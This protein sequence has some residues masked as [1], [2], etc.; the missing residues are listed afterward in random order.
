[1][2]FNLS[3]NQLEGE[4]PREG[5]FKNISGVSIIGNKE[6]CGGIPE[7][8]L[9]NCSN[10][11]AK[12]KGNVLSTKVIV[13]LIVSI[14]LASM[15]VVLLV[16]LCWRKCSGREIISVGLLPVGHLRVSYKELL[17]ATNGFASSNYIGGGSFG[18]VYK[19]NLLQQGK[20]VA[21]KVL[22]LENLGAIQS[23]TV[24]CEA[25]SKIRHRNLVRLIT[26][27]S[28]IDYKRQCFQSFSLESWLHDHQYESRHLNF[29]QMLDI[30]IDVA[31]A[32][33][34]LH[35]HCETLIV[36]RDLKPTNVLLDDDM[37]AH[38]SDFGMAK[39]LSRA[40]SNLGSE[41]ATSSVIKGTIGYLAPGKCQISH[42]IMLT[43]YI[44]LS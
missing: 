31:N 19:G 38:V 11:E 14:P 35:N 17:Q 7:I 21:V 16:I 39:L 4:V 30:A 44:S 3:F 40:A 9:P 25:L 27:C 22:N 15:L 20:P 34:Y 33:D 26:S 42:F 18:S 6:L 10:Q 8:E 36:H 29:N 2:S 41:Q 12:K 1:M 28:S 24:E 32:L 23:F 37:V 43:K 13:V 5:V